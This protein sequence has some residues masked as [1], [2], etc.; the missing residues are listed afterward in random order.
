MLAA[1]ERLG[2]N[3]TRKADVLARDGDAVRSDAV[4]PAEIPYPCLV[5]CDV[6]F[7]KNKTVRMTDYASAGKLWSS[8]DRFAVWL[9]ARFLKAEE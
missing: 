8:S 4:D 7:G 6:F 5:S 2:W 3:P 1:A 9:P